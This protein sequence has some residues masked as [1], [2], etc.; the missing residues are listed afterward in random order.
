MGGLAA[1][2]TAWKHPERIGLCAVMS[3]S[4]WWAKG[5][6]LI[7][8]EVAAGWMRQMRFWTCMGT[9]EGKGRGHVSPHLKRTRRLV[10]LFDGAGLVPGRDYCYWEVAGGEHNEAAWA[11]RFDK[12]LLYFFGW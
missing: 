9:R 1:L 3:P 6:V 4:L 11:A 2:T 8:L 5:R 12:V 7:E 10:E